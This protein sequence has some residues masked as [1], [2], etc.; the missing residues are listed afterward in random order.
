MPPTDMAD[1]EFKYRVFIIVVVIELEVKVRMIMVLFE[2]SLH[3]EGLGSGD[4]KLTASG[5]QCFFATCA[6]CVLL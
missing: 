5:M 6:S 4:A 2:Q 3:R 1:E